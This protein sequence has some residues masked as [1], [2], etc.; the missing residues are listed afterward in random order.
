MEAVVLE[1]VSGE[2]LSR[3][4]CAWTAKCTRSGEAN[5][6]E[7]DDKNVRRSLRRLQRFYRRKLC[8]RVLRVAGQLSVIGPIRDRKYISLNPGRAQLLPPFRSMFRRPLNDGWIWSLADKQSLRAGRARPST[9]PS[10]VPGRGSEVSSPEL[11]SPA[12]P[13]P[14]GC[15]GRSNDRGLRNRRG[16]GSDRLGHDRCLRHGVADDAN[17]SYTSWS[18]WHFSLLPTHLLHRPRWRR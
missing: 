6:I 16:A 18:E 17:S 11:D 5:V 3:R 2:T 13:R 9:R 8:L 14:P 10:A 7:Q 1:T 12:T 15:D 4:S